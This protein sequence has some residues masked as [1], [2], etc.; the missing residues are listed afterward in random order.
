MNKKFAAFFM[1][2]A[3]AALPL[4]SVVAADKSTNAVSETPA[5]KSTAK[6][7]VKKTAGK[8]VSI[9]GKVTAVDL[10]L[11]TVTLEKGKKQTVYQVTSETRFYA[12]E[13]PAIMSEVTIGETVEGRASALGDAKY[14]LKALYLKAK[15]K[16]SKEAAPAKAKA[17]DKK[18]DVKAPSPSKSTNSVPAA[19]TKPANP[20][21]P[22][23]PP[24]P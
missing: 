18:S 20:S 2:T 3:I 7:A 11:K 8:S 23:T 12:G 6:P 21:T 16:D 10:I 19:P 15:P 9:S 14:D 13:T 17:V 22:T 1:A 4:V 24:K 5:S